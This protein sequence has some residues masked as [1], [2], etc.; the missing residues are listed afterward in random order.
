MVSKKKKAIWMIKFVIIHINLLKI[1][2]PK[3]TPLSFKKVK[4]FARI[5]IAS[6]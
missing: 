4:Y 1:M 3:K 2:K 5:N 6:E